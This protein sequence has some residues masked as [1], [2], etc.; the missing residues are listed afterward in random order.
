MN[1]EIFAITSIAIS[2][3]M[4]PQ[5]QA[6][7]VDRVANWLSGSF[8][9]LAQS[10]R[11][12]DYLPISLRSCSVEVKGLQSTSRYLYIEQALMRSLENPYRQRVYRIGPS[13]DGGVESEIM[14]VK[15]SKS[16]VGFCNQENRVITEQDFEQRGCTV[17][18]QEQK[19]G[20][21][22]GSTKA[23]SCP[24]TF[25][26]AVQ[27]E[28]FVTLNSSLLLAWDKGLDA[29]NNQVWGPEKGPYEFALKSRPSQN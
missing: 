7:A 12:S 17:Y 9:S 24:S 13:A 25:N 2:G 3:N 14:L 5:Q 29:S 10:Q 23:G 27:V 6:S 15:N 20:A 8:D 19:D 1:L 18:L 21:F 26:G 16:F 11:D 28:S 4:N 22:S